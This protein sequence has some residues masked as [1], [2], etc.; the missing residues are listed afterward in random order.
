MPVLN[1]L[2]IP[3]NEDTCPVKERVYG[4]RTDSHI[5]II[6]CNISFY[7]VHEIQLVQIKDS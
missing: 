7:Y 3:V 5:Q 6:I 2:N 4:F 1:I